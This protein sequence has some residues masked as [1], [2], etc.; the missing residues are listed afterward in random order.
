MTS[1]FDRLQY[2][3]PSSKRTTHPMA[4]LALA[5]L[6]SLPLGCAMIHPGPPTE[7]HSMETI[8]LKKEN[9][10]KIVAAHVGDMVVIDLAENPTTGYRWTIGD[11]DRQVVQLQAADYEP[12]PPDGPLGAGG[13]R[14]FRFRMTGKGR[15]SVELRLLRD[16]ETEKSAVERFETAI[17]VKP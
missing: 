5:A 6:L 13:R 3:G 8:L 14:I 10:G 11:Y 16:W 9:T 12:P 15:T 7:G 4:R 17:V 2:A 1:R